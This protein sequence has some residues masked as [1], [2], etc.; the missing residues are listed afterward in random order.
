M[1]ALVVGAEIASGGSRDSRLAIDAYASAVAVSIAAR[2]LER[3]SEPVI[4]SAA[5]I[6]KKNGRAAETGNYG[7]H[8]A[9]V[10]DIAEGGSTSRER[11]GDTRFDAFEMSVVIQSDQGEFPVAQGSINILNIVEDV[12]LGDEQILPAVIV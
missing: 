5:T 1:E 4:C 11:L 9:V 7:I 3:N 2:A 12:A 8:A 10:V 6:E